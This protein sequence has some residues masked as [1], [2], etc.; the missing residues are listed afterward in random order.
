MAFSALEAR[1]AQVLQGAGQCCPLL[2]SPSSAPNYHGPL[3]SATPSISPSGS[4]Q[5]L[6]EDRRQGPDFGPSPDR[7]LESPAGP[8]GSGTDSQVGV[9]GFPRP[10][11][12][13]TALAPLPR[14]R[15]SPAAAPRDPAESSADAGGTRPNPARPR[16]GP[17]SPRA[18][19]SA[20]GAGSG[21]T[22]GRPAAAQA[23]GGRR[24][25]GSYPAPGTGGGGRAR[26]GAGTGA[27][28]PIGA[29]L[30]HS[31]ALGPLFRR[32]Q[33]AVQS[34]VQVCAFVYLSPNRHLL[35]HWFVPGTGPSI[36]RATKIIS[37]VY[38]R[39]LCQPQPR[40]ALLLRLSPALHFLG[41]VLPPLPF[42]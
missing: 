18:L 9:Q 37:L 6:G 11:S 2:C 20:R 5:P 19:T 17:P 24:E 38:P 10:Q 7:W 39:P 25:A 30:G 26:G 27:R 40:S 13:L 3:G 36:A 35:R 28:A 16:P 29:A 41:T 33:P 42:Q 1:A 34:F 15:R 21:R 23:S 32:L 31:A 4:V 22:S 12:P 8:I 14:H